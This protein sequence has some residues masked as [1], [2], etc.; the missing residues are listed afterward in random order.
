[1]AS[2]QPSRQSH[3]YSSAQQ[4]A[5]A[6]IIIRRQEQRL[7]LTVMQ[8][9]RQLPALTVSRTGGGGMRDRSHFIMQ[10][11]LICKISRPRVISRRLRVGSPFWNP[12]LRDPLLREVNPIYKN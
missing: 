12:L 10:V 9:G 4:K 7:V 3:Y 2:A 1:M 6:G 8:T 11:V 5:Q